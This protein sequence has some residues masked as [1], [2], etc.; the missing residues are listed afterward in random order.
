MRND[1]THK[2]FK[3]RW[4]SSKPKLSCT[5]SS[6]TIVFCFVS[7]N[8]FS[9]CAREEHRSFHNQQE[10]QESWIGGRTK[11]TSHCTQN[12]SCNEPRALQLRVGQQTNEVQQS[13]KISV[14]LPSLFGGLTLSQKTKFDRVPPSENR[15]VG[16]VFRC[17]LLRRSILFFAGEDYVPAVDR[18]AVDRRGQHGGCRSYP[19]RPSKVRRPK[20]SKGAREK[21]SWGT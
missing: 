18:Q 21:K 16:T 9:Q 4:C 15:S 11:Y 5:R 12:C 10:V 7:C 13:W 1:T 17:C 2:F 14:D 3:L 20:C 6:Q 8:N 19:S